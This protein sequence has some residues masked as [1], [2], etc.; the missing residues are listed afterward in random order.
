[1][2][3]EPSSIDSA[4][5]FLNMAAYQQAQIDRKIIAS[6]RRSLV[7]ECKGS[8]VAETY[9]TPFIETFDSQS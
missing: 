1:M 8:Q 9:E 6:L 3:A 5:P 2:G 7:V 4:S